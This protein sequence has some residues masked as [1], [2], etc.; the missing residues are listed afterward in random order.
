MRKGL[1][2]AAL[3]ALLC[4]LIP[5]APLAAPATAGERSVQD[6]GVAPV[7]SRPLPEA[8]GLFR[9][10]EQRQKELELLRN[11]YAYTRTE[12]DL[13]LDKAGRPARKTERT[14]E[15]FLLNG[16][17]VSRLVAKDGRP[18]TGAAALKE[19]E[20][21][22]KALRDQREKEKRRARLRKHREGRRETAED[23][24]RGMS[25]S[26]LLR[27]CRFV[28]PRRET[29]NGHELLVF[30][31]GP[32]PG[33]QARNRA[34]SWARKLTGRL[35][36]DE[37][38]KEVARVE[39]RLEDG[40]KMAGGVLL[41]LRRGATFVLEQERV[42]DEVWLPSYAEVRASGRVFLLKGFQVN[43]TQRFS[44]YRK[45]SV[46]TISSIHGPKR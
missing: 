34:E 37:Q 13:D 40:L 3:M 17:E 11:E 2:F 15:V 33:A 23:S 22:E 14:Y 12:T 29:L 46:E 10:I 42:N 26:D 45:F 38:H 21:A 41:S 24:N 30:D 19:Q 27:V 20:R 25:I 9:E 16:N 5:G 44:N 1:F 8:A 7:P 31:F 39:G 43:Q 36:I 28:N 32:L 18:L 4:G 6:L 35:W